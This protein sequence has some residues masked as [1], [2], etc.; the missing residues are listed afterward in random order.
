MH[1]TTKEEKNL[2]EDWAVDEWADETFIKR[3]W[4]GHALM[5]RW[6]NMKTQGKNGHEVTMAS[7]RDAKILNK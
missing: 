4:S 5:P 2:Q 6:V 7:A 1:V 3:R